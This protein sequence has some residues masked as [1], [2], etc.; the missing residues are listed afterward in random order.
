M[1][2][3]TGGKIYKIIAN[4]APDECYVGS[5]TE[6][7]LSNRMADHRKFYKKWKVGMRSMTRGSCDLFEAYGVENCRIVL[8]ELYPCQSKDELRAREQFWINQMGTFNIIRAFT[9]ENERLNDNRHDQKL[10]NEKHKEEKAKYRRAYNEENKEYR[11]RYNV[12]YRKDHSTITE[13]ECGSK[14][15]AYNLVRHMKT[16]KHQNF[17]KSK[18]PKIKVQLKLK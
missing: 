10:H 11:Q 6:R 3:Y 18:T 2:D 7:Y 15:V 5:T 13:C 8:I 9:T 4:Q 1:C 14:I 17:L 12:T 16:K